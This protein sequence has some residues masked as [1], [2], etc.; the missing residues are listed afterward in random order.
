MV[1]AEPRLYLITP[2]IADGPAF[3]AL[4]DSLLGSCEIACILLRTVP[5]E[6]AA[7]EATMRLLAE[8]AQRHSTACLVEDDVALVLAAGLDGVHLD[9]ANSALEPVLGSLQPTH[10]VGAGGLTTR[11]AA[12][13]A[14][15]AGADYLMFG[16]PDASETHAAVV[17]RVAWW[18]EIFNVPC[19]GYA[20][21]LAGIE[22]L[23]RAGADFIALC[24]AIFDDPRGAEIA[25]VEAAT[26]LSELRTA[27]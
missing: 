7:H 6:T 5:M 8:V 19:V 13:N 21:E 18:A 26:S 12:M 1:T 9:A 11:D 14:G 25:L 3:A 10:I 24:G 16:G 4:L 2:R 27:A 22:D 20:E 17:E 23:V 15:E